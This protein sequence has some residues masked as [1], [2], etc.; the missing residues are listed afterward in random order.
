MGLS[1]AVGCA[2]PSY[3]AEEAPP[4]PAAA[5]TRLSWD[6]FDADLLA[7]AVFAETNRVRREHDLRPLHAYPRLRGAAEVQ[8]FTNAITGVVSHDNPLPGRERAWDRVRRQGIAP[9]MVLENVAVTLVR[10][11]TG[12]GGAVRIVQRTDETGRGSRREDVA[13]DQLPWPTYAELAAKLVQQ[14][15]DSPPHR[16]N[17]LNPEVRYLACGVQLARSP[18]SG[19]IVHAIQVFMARP[20]Q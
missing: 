19:E 18:L 1:L 12:G 14:W 11:P 5:Q 6:R 9:G 10:E 8:A 3:R 20:E 16:A 13:A 4:T 7:A 2:A 15:M 17:V